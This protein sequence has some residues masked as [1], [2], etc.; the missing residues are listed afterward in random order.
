MSSPR[1]PTRDD[2][3]V[4]AQEAKQLRADFPDWAFHHHRHRVV[5]LDWEAKRH[6]YKFPP[7]GGVAWLRADSAE[8]LRE[9]LTEVERIEAARDARKAGR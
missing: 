8:R 7:G 9:L 1:E 3:A 6:P 5:D 2:L 4:W